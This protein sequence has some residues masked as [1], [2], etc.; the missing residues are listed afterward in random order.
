MYLILVLLTSN[1][2]LPLGL[3]H[4]PSSSSLRACGQSHPIKSQRSS[5]SQV[6]TSGELQRSVCAR[7]ALIESLT[8]TRPSSL[9]EQLRYL[10]LPGS[11]SRA[12]VS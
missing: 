10:K 1:V 9:F 8:L 6:S 2:L 3:A 5:A 11:S 12:M 4:L 7:S